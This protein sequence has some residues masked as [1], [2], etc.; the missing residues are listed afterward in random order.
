MW[1]HWL[2]GLASGSAVLCL[3]TAYI[4]LSAT[5]TDAGFC[6]APGIAPGCLFLHVLGRGLGHVGPGVCSCPRLVWTF[7]HLR[8]SL[9]LGCQRQLP[10]VRFCSSARLTALILSRPYRSIS[11]HELLIPQTSCIST[12]DVCDLHLRASLMSSA[13]IHIRVSGDMLLRLCTRCLLRGA[14][15]AARALSGYRVIRSFLHTTS[16]SNFFEFTRFRLNTRVVCCC[17]MSEPCITAIVFIIFYDKLFEGIAKKY[18]TYLMKNEKRPIFEKIMQ[19][20]RKVFI[21]KLLDMTSR[22]ESESNSGIVIFW[23]H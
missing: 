23:S 18:A 17:C 19:S 20:F 4:L 1:C 9:H 12:G 22:K 13:Y 3:R 11:R 14:R 8:A 7:L 6:G 15:M 16:I 21:Q 2:T 5:G 10:I